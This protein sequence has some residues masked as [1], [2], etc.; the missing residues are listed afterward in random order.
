MNE[1][2]ICEA[3]KRL[4]QEMQ[5]LFSVEDG[6]IGLSTRGKELFVKLEPSQKFRLGKLLLKS[7][8]KELEKEETY[9]EH[10][11]FT[12]L[13][14]IYEMLFTGS[15]INERQVFGELCETHGVHNVI[16]PR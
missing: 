12:C 15:S 1:R 16:A 2:L 13:T 5:V 6:V 7:N 8:R 9:D 11:V 14:L 3:L 10:Y 4:D